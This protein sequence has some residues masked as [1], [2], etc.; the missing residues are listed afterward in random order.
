M[1]T[2]IFDG[3]KEVSIRSWQILR[4]ESGR[5]MSD[6]RD[7]GQ[8][9]KTELEHALGS[10]DFSQLNQLVQDTVQASVSGVAEQMQKTSVQVKDAAQQVRKAYGQAVESGQR[11]NTYGQKIQSRHIPNRPMKASERHGDM[12]GQLQNR[13]EGYDEG[14]GSRG[15][16]PQDAAGKEAA[17]AGKQAGSDTLPKE[18]KSGGLF[19]KTGSVSSILCQVFGGIGIGLFGVT[20]FVFLILLLFIHA[21]G[22]LALFLVFLLLAAGSGLLLGEGSRQKAR[23]K[24]SQRYFEL[25]RKT[26]Y[27][28]ISSLSEAVGKSDSFVVKEL[29]TLISL[30][31]FPQGHLDKQQ[32]CFMLSDADYEEYQRVTRERENFEAEQG[33]ARLENV[34]SK[35]SNGTQSG[36]EAQELTEEERQLRA[37]IVEGQNYIRQIRE[38]NDSIPGEVF[39]QKLFRMEALLKEIFANLEKMPD[40]MSKMHK[41]MNYYLPT[42]LKLVT[43]YEQFERAPVQGQDVLSAKKEIENTVDTINDAFEELLNKLFASAAMDVTADAQVLKTILER[44]GLSKGGFEYVNEFR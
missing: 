18:V 36:Q 38:K 15:S 19:K 34:Q 35:A 6:N 26:G 30:G 9:F 28:N 13:T 1:V 12:Y 21:K 2:Y 8:Q 14:S 23:M 25:G 17:S 27:V 31:A 41:L 24:R 33:S 43:A 5:E 44:E 20:T 32:Q 16:R 10:G 39:S 11:Q 29:R 40:Q 3:K 42:T 22:I 7:Y 4:G 37:I